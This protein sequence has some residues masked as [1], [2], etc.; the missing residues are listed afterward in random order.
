MRRLL[1]AMCCTALLAGCFGK[2]GPVEEYLRL[3]QAEECAGETGGA[4]AKVGVG[5][6][7]LRSVDALD[8]QAVMLAEGR[9][10]SPSQ[11]W[12]WESPPGRMAEAALAAALDCSATLSAVWPVRYDS[13]WAVGLSGSLERF[14]VLVQE[15]RFIATVTL[16]AWDAKDGKP[17][18]AKTFAL[19]E[20]V[21]ALDAQGVARAGA[22]ALRR[23]GL[24]ARQW[25]EGLAFTAGKGGAK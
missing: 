20:P 21:S 11:R 6:R 7:K 10:M 24:E 18:G 15:K 14:E 13:A 16:Q 1:L 25:V 12:Y 17:L 4:K 8:R 3:G 2:A 22:Q 5:L 9:I 19:T 23:L